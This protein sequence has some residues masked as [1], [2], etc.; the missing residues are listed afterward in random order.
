M[1]LLLLIC[2]WFQTSISGLG[3]SFEFY[4]HKTTVPR[5]HYLQVLGAFQIQHTS[6]FT[7]YLSPWTS[8]SYSILVPAPGTNHQ[9]S[10]PSYKNHLWSFYLITYIQ[11]LSGAAA[12]K[13]WVALYQFSLFHTLLFIVVV[14]YCQGSAVGFHM[15][16]SSPVWLPSQ[17]V[18]HTLV[19]MNYCAWYCSTCFICT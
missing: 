6:K 11:H 8:P 12:S 1:G 2:S 7:L 9:L 10:C 4:V 5:Y 18:S 15:V 13:S 16:L 19:V 14:I 17:S 3:L